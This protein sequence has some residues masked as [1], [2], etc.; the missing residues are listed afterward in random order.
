MLPTF[1]HHVTLNP[2]SNTSVPFSVFF[3]IKPPNSIG[4]QM[5]LN[6]GVSDFDDFIYS[7]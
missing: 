4:I 6:C 7:L 2:K 3:A 1:V 5:Q